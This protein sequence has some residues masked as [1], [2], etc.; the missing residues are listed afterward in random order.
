MLLNALVTTGSTSRRLTDGLLEIIVYKLCPCSAF[1]EVVTD[2]R[3]LSKAINH[4]NE[5]VRDGGRKE[6]AE[7]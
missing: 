4:Y 2:P 3:E 5:P 7:H 6:E 1:R